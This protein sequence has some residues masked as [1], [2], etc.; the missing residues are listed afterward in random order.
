MN[1][2]VFSLL[3]TTLLFC[4]PTFAQKEKLELKVKFGKISEEEIKMT[5]YEKDSEATAVVLFDKGA[6]SYNIDDRFGFTSLFERHIR[7]K[8]FKKTA[9]SL[10]N[11]K[12]LYRSNGYATQR[13]FDIKAVCYNKMD[14]KITETKLLSENI[15]DESLT[16][17]TSVKKITIPNVQ[18]GSIFELTYKITT[19]GVTNIRDWD[20]Q[21]YIPVLWSEYTA[22]I[23][24]FF[25]FLPVS[26]GITPFLLNSKDYGSKSKAMT[27]D[28]QTDNITNS[29]ARGS[30]SAT[31]KTT[32]Y[33]WIQQ[34][35]PSIKTEKYMTSA[36]DYQTKVSF[37]LKGFNVA[38]LRQSI[39]LGSNQTKAE[40]TAGPYYTLT[41]SWEKLG[42]ELMESENFGAVIEKKSATKDEVESIIAGLGSPKDKLLAIYNYIGKN[43]AKNDNE[44]LLLSQSFNDLLKNKKGSESDLNLLFC[45]MLRVAGLDASPMV[46]STRKNGRLDKFYPILDRLD[47]TLVYVKLNEK[48]SMV[49]DIAGYPQPIGLLP[50]DDLNGEG[51]VIKDKKTT[52]WAMVKNSLTTK[53]FSAANF[54]LNT[55]GEL[56][57][58]LNYT[59]TGYEALEYRNMIKEKGVE[60]QIQS[61]TKDLVV[62][63]K[64]EKYK[65]ENTEPNSELA[66]KAN[67]NLKTSSCSNK[68][69]NKIYVNALNCLSDKN[70]PFKAETRLYNIDFGEPRD[71]FYQLNITIP[72]GYKVEEMP[73]K[74]RIQ[75]PDNS[76]KFEYL[77]SIKDNIITIN[78]KFN[79]KRSIFNVEEYKDLKEIYA[80]SLAKMGEQIVLIKASN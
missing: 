23:P 55:E 62:D 3:F 18:E 56:S 41:N 73:K 45:N 2:N 36:K 53:R 60:K 59:F 40:L 75:L 77:S 71:E 43:Y 66:L 38:E 69:D 33:H 11:F 16:K 48:D 32:I 8:I 65:F 76:L 80:K 49:V 79:I 1:K 61:I 24:E 68:S 30:A 35:V 26:Q 44:S 27:F 28:V 42:E 5:S 13:L 21:E 29:K 47:K 74:A 72:D 10:A 67:V 17:S 51:F 15:A 7:V 34:H 9:F 22:E 14:D 70:N 37:Q 39:T 31:W 63:G 46:I 20:F 64:L 57:G 58:E 78:T 19:E 4:L 25:D 50:F 54:I 12:L 52:N 6:L